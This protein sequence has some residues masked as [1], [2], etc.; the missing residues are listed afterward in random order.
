MRGGAFLA[1]DCAQQTR[2]FAILPSHLLTVMTQQGGVGG[3]SA[4]FSYESWHN[5]SAPLESTSP[6]H[7]P[8]SSLRLKTDG[9]MRACPAVCLCRLR[10][11]G[12]PC[13]EALVE[14]SGITGRDRPAVCEALIRLTT[15]VFCCGSFV[16]EKSELTPGDM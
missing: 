11:S 15:H 4:I 5:K 14:P 12:C 2:F 10:G 3:L 13:D 7:D 1:Q 8:S 6:Q 9:R 16:F